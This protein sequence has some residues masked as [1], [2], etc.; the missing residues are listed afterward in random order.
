[1]IATFTGTRTATSIS[2]PEV[3]IISDERLSDWSPGRFLVVANVLAW[4]QFL[5]QRRAD[6]ARDSSR[7]AARDEHQRAH[8][9]YDDECHEENARRQQ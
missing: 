2:S 8:G 1:L 7:R 5:G 6:T 3:V 9:E 4:P